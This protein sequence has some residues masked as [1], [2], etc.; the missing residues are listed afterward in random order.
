MVDL[1]KQ[2]DEMNHQID[3]QTLPFTETKISEN[4]SIREFDIKFP[5][6][7]YKWHIDL[8][9]RLIEPL[10]ENDWKFQFDNELPQKIDKQLFIKA[11]IFHR[12]IKG[13]KNLKLKIVKIQ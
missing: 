1:S 12:L 10:E 7:L 9:D 6:H 5:E 4:E 2:Y 3:D 13:T 11:G 8:E